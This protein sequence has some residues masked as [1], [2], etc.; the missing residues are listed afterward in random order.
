VQP[1]RAAVVRSLLGLEV[2]RGPGGDAV[3]ELG[4]VAD[5]A[6][7]FVVGPVGGV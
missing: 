4:V 2:K 1:D 3:G 6:Y 5:L 7:R